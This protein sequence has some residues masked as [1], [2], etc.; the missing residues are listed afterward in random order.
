M[1]KNQTIWQTIAIGLLVVI[2]DLGVFIVVRE[3]KAVKT[4]Q[5]TLDSR[6]TTLEQNTQ[7]IKQIY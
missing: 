7:I 1:S 2:V 4:Q 6:V 5:K 3:V